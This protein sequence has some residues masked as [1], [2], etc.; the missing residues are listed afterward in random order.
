MMKVQTKD[1]TLT[2]E[3]LARVI[4]EVKNSL[5]EWRE[6]PRDTYGVLVE[7]TIVTLSTIVAKLEAQAAL[8]QEGGR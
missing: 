6:S 3:E 1:V 7:S 5:R 2:S 4:I 8:V